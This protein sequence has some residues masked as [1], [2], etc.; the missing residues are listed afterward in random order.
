M[1]FLHE[2]VRRIEGFSALDR[3]AKPVA[4]VVGN[5]VRPRVARNL[6]S[7]TNLGHPLPPMLTDL[8]IGA[9]SMSTLLDSER[10]DRNAGEGRSIGRHTLI[11]L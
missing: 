4:G 6:L 1:A 10:P 5:A 3:V 8:P 11:D 2:L 9:W 7:G